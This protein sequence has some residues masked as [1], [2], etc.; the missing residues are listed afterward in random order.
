MYEDLMSDEKDGE[1]RLIDLRDVES[2]GAVI[3]PAITREFEEVY[4]HGGNVRYARPLSWFIDATI[5][6]DALKRQLQDYFQ[7][8]HAR[9]VFVRF[10]HHSWL[11]VQLTTPDGVVHR[12][13]VADLIERTP[14]P[15]RQ[16]VLD[17]IE[18]YHFPLRGLGAPTQSSTIEQ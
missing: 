1:V 11:F 14:A 15:T 6:T 10:D 13:P 12:K 5:A 2:D 4:K 17:A 7:T 16:E 18:Q 3:D 8:V 9:G